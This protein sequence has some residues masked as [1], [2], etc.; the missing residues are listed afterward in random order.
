MQDEFVHP[1][2]YPWKRLG[3]LRR[4]YADDPTYNI[5][6]Q[7][8]RILKPI[9]EAGKSFIKN[10]YVLKEMLKDVNLDE[11]CLM[12]SLDIVGLYPNIPLQ[13]ALEVIR[14]KLEADDTLL[15]RTDWNVDGF[16]LNVAI[17]I[18]WRESQA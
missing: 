18:V 13:K 10:S 15:S 2:K 6:K 3:L 14:Q 12:A 16:F 4:T 8:T 11:D 17:L 5:C 9:S 1:Q 7:W